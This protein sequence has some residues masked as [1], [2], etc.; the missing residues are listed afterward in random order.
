[1]SYQ[2]LIEKALAEDD[3]E[4]LRGVL[5]HRAAEVTKHF[6]VLLHE[7]ARSASWKCYDDMMGRVILPQLQS[8]VGGTPLLHRVCE[9]GSPDRVIAILKKH[10]KQSFP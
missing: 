8:V 4:L 3:V 9:R 1:M 10:R 2:P 5:K 7:A 6:P